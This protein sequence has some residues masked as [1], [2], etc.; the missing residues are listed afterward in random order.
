M[1]LVER[2]IIKQG[3]KFYKELD[4]LAW[5]SK[6]L[7]NYSN[8]LVR[9]SFINEGRYLNNIDIFH[10]VKNH[11]TYKA[12]PAKVSNQVLI[13]LHRNW[14]SFFAAQRSYNTDPSK[15]K[16]RPRLPYY[17]DINKGRFALVYEAKAV[18]K[19]FLQRGLLNP[20]KTG[21]ELPTKLTDVLEVRVIPRCGEYVIEAV[22]EQ[23][24]QPNAGLDFTKAAAIDLGVDNLACITSNKKGFQPLLVNGRVL[25][26]INQQ[27][28]KYKAYFQSKLPKNRRSSNRIQRLT[29]KRNHR[30]DTYLHRA[31]R[32][33]INKLTS[34]GIGLLVIGNNPMWKQEVN[35]G[36]TNN[37]NFVSIPYSRL[38]EMLRYKAELVGIQ[39]VV[40]EESYTSRASFLDLDPIPTY[41]P[42]VRNTQVFSGSRVKRAWYKASDGRLIHADVNGSYNILR[43][44]FP[45]AFA[46]G[47]GGIAVCPVRI[48]F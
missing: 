14:K 16:G 5:R 18:S 10:Q 33:I 30:I 46:E 34:E 6:N 24:P 39:V 8:Y 17:K 35:L 9:Q 15:F 37:Q 45:D 36:S 4:D 22:Y 26:S 2:H 47:I 3:H 11:E 12:L 19:R 41:R 23:E 31:S 42:G 38:I 13:M 27:Y 29:A 44:V 25:K 7:Y 1:R 48:S 21:I 28:N 32:M 20:S 43:K 40:S